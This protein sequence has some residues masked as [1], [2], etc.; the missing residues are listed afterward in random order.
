MPTTNPTVTAARAS[1]E[2]ELAAAR[3]AQQE[4]A[5]EASAARVESHRRG[6]QLD[7]FKRTRRYKLAQ[8]IGRPLD[9]IR[10]GRS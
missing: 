4:L 1:L 2:A 5:L 7:T 9:L 10:G 8:T 6:E 3:T